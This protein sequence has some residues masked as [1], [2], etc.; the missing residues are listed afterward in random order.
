M[1]IDNATKTKLFELG[2]IIMTTGALEALD[3]SKQ[4]PRELLERHQ[5]GDWGEELCEGDR[6]ENDFSLKNGFRLLSAYKTKK[7]QK[8]W[9]ITEHDRSSTIR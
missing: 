4:T 6:R 2:R 7:G 9:I 5:T 3:E 8:L 1:S